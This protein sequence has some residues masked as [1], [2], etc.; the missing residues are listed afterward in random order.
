MATIE[1][2]RDGRR[3]LTS[4]LAAARYNRNPD[5]MRKVLSRLSLEPVGELDARTPLWDALALDAE[6]DALPGQGANLRKADGSAPIPTSDP[7]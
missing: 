1:I 6:M 5:A 2:Y 4:L 3:V 7:S